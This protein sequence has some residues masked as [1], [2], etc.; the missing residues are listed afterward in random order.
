MSPWPSRGGGEL[1]TARFAEALSI[2]STVRVLSL[3]AIHSPQPPSTIEE[4]VIRPGIPPLIWSYRTAERPL[5]PALPIHLAKRVERHVAE[6]QPDIVVFDQTITTG[7]LDQVDFSGARLVL[8]AHNFDTDLALQIDSEAAWWSPSKSPQLALA[9]EAKAAQMCDLLVCCS[10]T[11]ADSFEDKTGVK[12]VVIPNPLPDE[13]AFEIPIATPRYSNRDILFVGA[14]VYR[15]NRIAVKALVEAF[16]PKLPPGA[17]I[18]LVG[19]SADMLPCQVRSAKNVEVITDPPEVL[20]YLHDVGYTVMPITEGSGTRLKV[21]EAM[22]AGVVTI[23]TGKAVE[24]LG[25]VPE[26]HFAL[27]ET[28]DG[29]FGRYEELIGNP[30]KSAAIATAAR[31]YISEHYSENQFQRRVNNLFSLLQTS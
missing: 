7:L 17:T 12:G 9:Q 16:S 23:A 11:D 15:P 24:G 8:N 29:L 25:L 22:A 10:D 19:K 21:V 31:Q 28:P 1:R 18:R 20:P 4:V 30:A 14:M 13:R 6:F 5:A 26:V 2:T 27:A 3:Y